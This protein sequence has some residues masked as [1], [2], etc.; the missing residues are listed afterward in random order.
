MLCAQEAIQAATSERD[1]L[2]ASL[3]D[4]MKE[5]EA[6]AG[7]R[8]QVEA[9]ISALERAFQDAGERAQAATAAAASAEDRATTLEAQMEALQ[10]QHMLICMHAVAPP[11]PQLRQCLKL[12]HR[13]APICAVKHSKGPA[14]SHSLSQNACKDKS[15]SHALLRQ[16]R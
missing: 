6:S 3:A 15:A 8:S 13:G 10:V 7:S 14:R 9:E 4:T 12:L 11:G 5:L 16:Q 1:A 2:D